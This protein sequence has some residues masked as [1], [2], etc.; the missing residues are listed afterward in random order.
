MR[1]SVYV[2]ACHKEN[3]YPMCVQMAP[4][5]INTL[6]VVEVSRIDPPASME[7]E[8]AD[9]ERIYKKLPDDGDVICILFDFPNGSAKMVQVPY[10]SNGHIPLLSAI[11]FQWIK[12]NGPTTVPKWNHFGRETK[13]DMQTDSSINLLLNSLYNE[14]ALTMGICPVQGNVQYIIQVYAE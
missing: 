14:K 13:I 3:A 10:Q 7:M 8:K 12:N 1:P 6:E 11:I 4:L 9:F 5:G 2:N